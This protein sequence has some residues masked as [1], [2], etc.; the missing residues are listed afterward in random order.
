MAWAVRLENVSKRFRGAAPGYASLAARLP[1]L[2]RRRRDDDPTTSTPDGRVPDRGS[3]LALDDVSFEVEQGE[4]FGLIG[5]NGAGKSTAL[6]LV[7]RISYPTSGRVRVRGRV[8]A[9]IEVGSAV[10][11]ELT[12]A[13]TSGSTAASSDWAARRSG[14]ASTRSST[15]PS[16]ARR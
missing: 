8:G 11:L 9:L 16:S 15:S 1:R 5:A 13:R 12:G 10:H 6:R 4:A 3:V 7:S 2:A 14:H